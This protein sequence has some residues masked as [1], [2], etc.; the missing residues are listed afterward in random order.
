MASRLKSSKRTGE[1]VLTGG[2]SIRKGGSRSGSQDPRTVHK[3]VPLL[4]FLDNILKF[5]KVLLRQDQ[6]PL[7]ECLVLDLTESLGTLELG[8]A[9]D[10]PDLAKNR[11]SNSPGLDAKS[12][13]WMESCS[14]IKMELNRLVMWKFD[15]TQRKLGPAMKEDSPVYSV[16]CESILGIGEILISRKL[17]HCLPC[18]IL[19]L[20]TNS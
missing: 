8:Q 19:F 6:N 17:L 2:R 12:E 1:S 20:L 16:V 14:V 11:T 7:R 15:V 3:P 13:D 18:Y 10:L 5:S 4:E 9:N